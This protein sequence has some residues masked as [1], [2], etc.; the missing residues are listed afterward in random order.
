MASIASFFPSFPTSAGSF[1]DRIAAIYANRDKIDKERELKR[2]QNEAGSRLEALYQQ[3]QDE[4]EKARIDDLLSQLPEADREAARANASQWKDAEVYNGKLYQNRDT[5]KQEHDQQIRDQVARKQA[6]MRGQDYDAEVAK[7][8]AA[9]EKAKVYFQEQ[10]AAMGG[11]GAITPEA[12]RQLEAQHDAAV[13]EAQGKLDAYRKANS[14]KSGKPKSRGAA[15][16]LDQLEA[17][18]RDAADKRE[19]LRGDT[20][21]YAVAEK[22]Y[23]RGISEDMKDLLEA[24]LY[25]NRLPDPTDSRVQERASARA[26]AKRM[27]EILRLGTIMPEQAKAIAAQMESNAQYGS[28]A[29]DSEIKMYLAEQNQKARA[30]DAYRNAAI[31]ARNEAAKLTLQRYKLI[32]QGRHN[33]AKEAQDAIDAQT[34]IWIANENN[35]ARLT[36]TSMAGEYGMIG[37]ALTNGYLWSPGGTE[38]LDRYTKAPQGTRAGLQR[39]LEETQ[40]RQGRVLFPTGV[41]GLSPVRGGQTVTTPGAYPWS[42]DKKDRVEVDVQAPTSYV[43]QWDAEHP[44]KSASS[45]GKRTGGSKASVTSKAPKENPGPGKRWE[46]VSGLGWTKVLAK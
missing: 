20:S 36:G 38:I 11:E 9:A 44:A 21:K 6:Q 37:S 29:S 24:E 39:Q 8:R 26:L 43:E 35:V 5:L 7:R 13:A 33:K 10:V 14:D 32:E 31:A 27:P 22:E 34:R 17:S 19:M 42:H 16:M 3:S 23:T 15:A 18:V 25:S 28:K 30:I 41:P 1:T 45:G 4:V 46:Y 40:V 2:Q 12:M